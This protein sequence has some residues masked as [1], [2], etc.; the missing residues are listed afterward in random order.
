MSYLRHIQAFL[1]ALAALAV[2]PALLVVGAGGSR[3]A[4]SP[5]PEPPRRASLATAPASEYNRPRQGRTS[6]CA[7]L[8]DPT[9]LIPLRYADGTLRG[10]YV[11]GQYPT[12]KRQLNE[13]D[14][15]VPGRDACPPGTTEIDARE[16]VD[17][18]AGKMLFH[19][20]GGHYAPYPGGIERWGQYGHILLSDLLEPPSAP[21]PYDGR[22]VGNG[23]PCAVA[24]KGQP[25]YGEYFIRPTEIPDDMWYK[26]PN[27]KVTGAGYRNY[28][29]K[30]HGGMY[31]AWNWV[32]NGNPSTV[33]SDNHVPGGGY[34][35]AVLK[36]GMGFER[37]N[38]APL[39]TVS[40]GLDNEQNGWVTVVYGR[41]FTGKQWLYG[42]VIHSYEK[43]AR[44]STGQI[45]KKHVEV[46]WP[47][48][49]GPVP[50]AVLPKKQ[51]AK[52]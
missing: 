6:D 40:Y 51:A 28:G 29:D 52:E 44:N 1:T 4:G 49:R 37:C 30:G 50:G 5:K 36:R 17:S 27:G 21:D 14:A 12:T 32:Q 13:R 3:V 35:R 26:K 23:K 8:R 24:K 15:K 10:Y 46:L 11:S 19:P 39:K 43:W 9:A 47:T 45:E 25:A 34:V 42:W 38:V 16:V 7:K 2:M 22:P 33:E 48:S 31:M 20:G 18:P 41:T